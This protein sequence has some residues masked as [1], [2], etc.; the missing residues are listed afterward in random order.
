[1]CSLSRFQE[2]YFI[3]HIQVV[4]YPLSILLADVV[5]RRCTNSLFGMWCSGPVRQ[6]EHFCYRSPTQCCVYAVRLAAFASGIGFAGY[7]KLFARH[8]GLNV[9]SDKM[10]HRV[11]EEAYPH[12]TEMLDEICNLGKAEMKSSM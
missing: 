9:T 8:L 5:A 12:I 11:I 6:L 4:L 7:H 1:M 3:T 10:F 2:H